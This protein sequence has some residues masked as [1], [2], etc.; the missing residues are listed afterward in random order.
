VLD[1][2]RHALPATVDMRIDWI[3]HQQDLVTVPLAGN[4]SYTLSL[5]AGPLIVH[6]KQTHWLGVTTTA[7][8]SVGD[9]TGANLFCPNG[10]ANNDNSVDLL[11]LGIVL[12]NFATA[13]Q[14]GISTR[15]ALPGLRI[16]ELCCRTS[17]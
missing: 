6:L 10:D 7:D 4:G 2:L 9:A 1:L 17:A 8:T 3:G 16:W 15:T 5:P 14:T 13:V 12:T 11:D